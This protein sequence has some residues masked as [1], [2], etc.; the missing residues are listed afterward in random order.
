MFSTNIIIFYVVFGQNV[1]ALGEQDSEW[2]TRTCFS[3]FLKK[4]PAFCSDKDAV[5]AQQAVIEAKRLPFLDFVKKKLFPR[6]EEEEEF[7]LNAKNYLW[8]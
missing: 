1:A 8:K 5:I 2:P 4:N 7:C 6:D 3:L